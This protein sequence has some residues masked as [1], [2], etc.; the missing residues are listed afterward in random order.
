MSSGFGVARWKQSSSERQLHPHRRRSNFHLTRCQPSLFFENRG[1]LITV[2]LKMKQMFLVSMLIAFAIFSSC[3]KQSSTTD[4]DIAQR[5]TELDAREKALDAR[6]KAL[7]ARDNALNRPARSTTNATRTIP[8][9]AQA[10]LRSL[11]ADP[12][13]I[14]AERQRRLQE[15]IAERQRKLQDLQSSRVPNAA[16]SPA[17]PA[18]AAEAISPSPSPTPE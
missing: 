2:L 1:K 18:S 6:E 7:D 3:Q 12:N 15:R 11:I 14:R 10:Q 5:K 4:Q 9:E 13:Q 16:V 8:P 17:A